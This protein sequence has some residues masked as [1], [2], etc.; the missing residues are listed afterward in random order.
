MNCNFV[1]DQKSLKGAQSPSTIPLCNHPVQPQRPAPRRKQG[2]LHLNN[3]RG[4]GRRARAGGM[5]SDMKKVVGELG[6]DG[7][8]KMGEVHVQRRGRRDEERGGEMQIGEV[9]VGEKEQVVCVPKIEPVNHEMWKVLKYRSR[10]I[11]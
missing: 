11:A 7:G 4:G 5:R 8:E 10:E 1:P 2:T 6:E 3:V 9:E